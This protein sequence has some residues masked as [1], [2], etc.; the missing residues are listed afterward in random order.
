MVSKL[1]LRYFLVFL[2]LFSFGYGCGAVLARAQENDVVSVDWSVTAVPEAKEVELSWENSFPTANY[3]I[4]VDKGSG[5]ADGTTVNESTSYTVKNLE[6]GGSYIFKIAALGEDFEEISHVTIRVETEEVQ[7]VSPG[8]VV[9]NEIAWMG[10]SVSYNDE[11]IELYNNTDKDLDLTGWFLVAEDGSLEISL[12]GEIPAQGYFLLER[13]DNDTIS[14]IEADLIYTG[15]LGNSGEYLKLLDPTQQVVDEIA[16]SESWFAGDNETKHSM[17]RRLPEEEGSSKTNWLT[18]NGKVICGKD[19]ESSKILGTPGRKNSVYGLEYI[20]E[21]DDAAGEEVFEGLI[22]EVKEQE[23]GTEVTLTGYVTAPTSIF[24]SNYFY[25]QDDSAGIKVNCGAFENCAVE[26]GNE[27]RLSC[28]LKESWDEFYI[29]MEE[30]DD[31]EILDNGNNCPNPKEVKT[32]EVNEDWEGFLVKVSGQI[33]DNIS[34]TTFYI[35]DGSGKAKIY[36]KTDDIDVPDKEMGDQVVAVGVVSQWGD[37]KDGTPNYRVMPRYQRDLK[38]GEDKE[39][40]SQGGDVL[41]VSQLP[42]TGINDDFALF[43]GKLA[44]CFGLFLRLLL[45]S[46]RLF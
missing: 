29:K 45:Y 6:P 19:A 12:A 9:I 21:E 35:D 41:G 42:V 1:P 34:G 15:A 5:F 31:L 25:L 40:L 38:I 39:I 14:N 43:F 32:G 33:V 26:L 46:Y 8:D 4:Y 2:F 37:L 10:T 11:W 17:E 30:N 20:S 28:F 3:K 16:C 36:V 18:N 24:S 23:E 22:E 13:T 7:K 27:V 44:V